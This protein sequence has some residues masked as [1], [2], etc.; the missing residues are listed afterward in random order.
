MPD[1]ILALNAG[2]SSIKFGL[3][4]ITGSGDPRLLAKG[5]LEDAGATPHFIVK[6]SS[7][8]VLADKSWDGTQPHEEMLR[9]LLDWVDRHL[10]SD[11]LTMA[12]HRV[13]HGGAEFHCPIL[14]DADVVAAIAQLTPLAPLHQPRCLEPIHT[15]MAL[16]PTLA[17][18]ACF[19][20]AF[21][22]D[23]MPPVSRYALPL[24]YEAAGL[25]KYGFHGLS[26]EYIAGELAR[27]APTLVA[28]RT[29]VAHLGSGASLCA[30][31]A[32]RSIDTTMGFSAL[33]GL[34]MGT[35]CGALD[36]G[37]ILYLQQA[38]GLSVAE[39]EKLLY[40]DS[41]LLGVSGLSSDIRALL[42][43]AAPRAREAIDLF[44]FSIAKHVAVMAHSLGGLDGLVFT[45]G[46]GE[47]A[48]VIRSMVCE[49]LAWLGVR[50]DE[51]ANR[52]GDVRISPDASGID[53]RVMKTDEEIMIA[54]HALALLQQVN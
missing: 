54:R 31:R 39:V 30:M 19:D 14:L 6:D 1:A 7:G 11:K 22:H 40:K 26:Y 23:L 43:S 12:G 42:D 8:V 24:H 17:Q 28:G 16:R 33:D 21:H 2:S 13:V 38:H 29:I 10:G 37:A 9:H 48:A 41:G 18:M 46:I 52:K 34:V 27:S 47:N 32:G 51:T 53:V 20:T 25:R 4:E 50:L 36:P 49:R 35:R 44:V 15:L 5:T 45:G 3:F